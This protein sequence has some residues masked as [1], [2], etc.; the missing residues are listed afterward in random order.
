M[1]LH[2]LGIDP[3]PDL[4]QPSRQSLLLAAQACSETATNKSQLSQKLDALRGIM[5]VK[6]SRLLN[7]L[8]LHLLDSIEKDVERLVVDANSPDQFWKSAGDIL[9]D[10]VND[11]PNIGQPV[12]DNIAAGGDIE[13][14][15]H[16]EPGR[17]TL[18]LVRPSGQRQLLFDNRRQTLTHRAAA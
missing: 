9:I 17:V 1:T 5:P 8:P 15:A 6:R 12:Q 4:I 14:A 2:I 11:Q 7:F 16:N 3:D 13:I 18:T 10:I